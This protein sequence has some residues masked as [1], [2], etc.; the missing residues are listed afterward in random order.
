M[1]RLLRIAGI[2]LLALL[3]GASARRAGTVKPKKP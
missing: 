2:V 1:P 3:P